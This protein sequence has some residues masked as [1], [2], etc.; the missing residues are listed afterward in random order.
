M[1]ILIALDSLLAIAATAV[2]GPNR[3]YSSTTSC[4]TLPERGPCHN[5]ARHAPTGHEWHTRPDWR[6]GPNRTAHS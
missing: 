4:S 1:R 3:S 2:A 6:G 5:R